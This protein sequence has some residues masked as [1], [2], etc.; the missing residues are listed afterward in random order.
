MK[1]FHRVEARVVFLAVLL[2]APGGALAERPADRLVATSPGPFYGTPDGGEGELVAFDARLAPALGTL[3]AG[4]RIAVDAWPVAPG[5]ARTVVLTRTEVYS[6]DARIVAIG[7]GG[8]VEVPRSTWVFFQGRDVAGRA[9]VALALDPATGVMRGL[10]ISERGIEE[11]RPPDVWT[12]GRHRLAAPEG[13][14]PAGAPLNWECGE[15]GLPLLPA[16]AAPTASQARVALADRTALA[17]FAKYAIVAIDTDNEFMGTK[18]SNNTTNAT[19]YIANLFN[20]MNLIYERDVQLHLLEGYTILRLSSTTDPYTQNSNGNASTAELSEFGSYWNSHYGGVKRALAAMLSGKQPGTGSASGIAWVAPT[21]L[22]SASNGYSFSKVFMFAQDTSANDVFITAHEIGHN[23]T[24]PHTHCYA[25]PAPDRCFNGESCY[26]GATSCPASGTYQGVTTTGTL[27]SYCHTLS[28]C[29]A[30]L[31]FHPYTMSRYFNIA[32]PAASSCVFSGSVVP[33]GPSVSGIVPALGATAG[34]T[35]VT[36]NG[37]GFLSGATAAFID[38]TGSVSLTSVVF[39]N[40]GKLTAVSP[41][42]AAGVMDVVVFNPDNSTGTLSAGFTYSAGPPP[43]SVTSISPNTGAASGGTPVTITGASFVSGAT[44]SIG[45]VAATGVSFVNATTLTATTGA[46]AAG[47]VNV[48]VTNPDTQTGTLSNGY[49][50]AAA[51]VSTSL[52][53]VTPCRILDTRNANGPYGGPALGGGGARRTFNVVAAPCGIPASAKALSVNLT[54]TQPAAAG[55]LA[56]YPGNGIPTGTTS[57]SFA[58]G[59]TH[60][61]NAFLYLATDGTGT[62]GVENDSAGTVHFILDVNGYL[63]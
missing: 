1:V 6:P 26:T 55:S 23:F 59:Q 39:V 4:E 47:L 17:A 8:E 20:Q 42:H 38:L 15:E 30:G 63:R 22:C 32:I 27:M 53:T 44:V 37:S 13:R 14:D 50:Y 31:V 40:S 5:V 35:A 18:F 2:V 10:V 43:P 36:I 62:F 41:A 61:N 46:H 19:N 60:A 52:Y 11:L 56:L 49:F 16:E 57:I 25:D 29:A 21:P 28:G 48:V 7:A 24:S 51:A 58:V 45:G 34:G 12:A 54:V 9:R 3:A 33:A